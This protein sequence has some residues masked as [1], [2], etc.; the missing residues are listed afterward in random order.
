MEM[1]SCPGDCWTGIEKSTQ[2]GHERQQKHYILNFP[3]TSLAEIWVSIYFFLFFV[4]FCFGR[5][6]LLLRIPPYRSQFGFYLF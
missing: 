3:P 1:V 2:Q 5:T 4:F 6:N